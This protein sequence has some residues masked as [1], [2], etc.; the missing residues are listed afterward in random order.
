MTLK[1]IPML[2]QATDRL[3]AR[4]RDRGLWGQV[5]SMLTGHPCGLF[6][7]EK[8]EANCSVRTRSD[9]GLQTVPLHQIQGSEGRGCFKRITNFGLFG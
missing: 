5:W 6:P 7:L 1:E 3:Y 4:A 2:N 8:I 9:A